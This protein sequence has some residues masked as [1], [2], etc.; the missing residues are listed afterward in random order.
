M[1]IAFLGAYFLSFFLVLFSA[2][3]EPMIPIFVRY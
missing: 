3:S 1:K 2:V